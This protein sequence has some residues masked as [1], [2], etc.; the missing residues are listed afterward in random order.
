MSKKPPANPKDE[1]F[2]DLSKQP[3]GEAVALPLR[4][5]NWQLSIGKIGPKATRMDVEASE[6]DRK[7]VI[8]TLELLG[9]PR[10]FVAYDVRS[11]AG[12]HYRLQGRVVADVV[13]ACVSTGEPVDEHIDAPFDVEFWPAEE[14]GVGGKNEETLDPYSGDPPEP[15]DDDI[16]DAGRIAY[17]TL[18]ISIEPFPRHPDAGEPADYGDTGKIVALSPFSALRKLK[19][20]N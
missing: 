4:G 11:I 12:G 6:A 2:P 3:A 14:I 1:D 15:L 5:R 16:I 18:A 20:K 17:E 8:A 9:L 10:L 7:A 19:D 13:Q